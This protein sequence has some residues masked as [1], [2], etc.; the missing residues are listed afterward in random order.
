MPDIAVHDKGTRVDALVQEA[1]KSDS[2]E[3][4]LDDDDF[5]RQV[6]IAADLI[7]EQYVGW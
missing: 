7:V 1:L 4:Y 5:A 3:R 6:R 2:I